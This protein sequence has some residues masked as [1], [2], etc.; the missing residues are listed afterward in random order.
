MGT[1]GKTIVVI[2]HSR[3]VKW[4]QI[5][6]ASIKA[7]PCKAVFDVM[8][9]NNSPA[10]DE[11]LKALTETEL[12]EGIRIEENKYVRAH[13]GALDYTLSIID[14]E[15]YP[16]FFSAETD[17][18]ALRDGWLD[19]FYGF[20]R[21]E[22]VAMAGWFWPGTDREYI[23]TGGCLY[24]TAI[25][26]RIKKQIHQ[27]ENLMICYGSGLKKRLWLGEENA[28]LNTVPELKEAGQS[29]RDSLNSPYQGPFTEQR[30][31]QEIWSKRDIKFYQEPGAWPYYRLQTEYECVKVPG[32]VSYF[33]PL[34]LAEGTWYGEP[35]EE[36]WWVHGWAGTVSHNYEIMKVVDKWQ[37]DALPVWIEREDTWWRETVPESARNK[38]L[39]LGLVRTGDDEKDFILNH[40]NFKGVV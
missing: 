32:R 35:L 17:C 31:F 19:W 13:A 34:H 24:N 12:G 10:G 36:A 14:P 16:Y 27:N 4:L 23:H 38:V 39:E 8:V 29:Y 37:R 28:H 7:H 22:W 11:S 5:V 20:M 6:V 2:P 30:G 33:E 25:L 18:V 21:D 3:T 40:P 26:N 15:E 9:V 1:N